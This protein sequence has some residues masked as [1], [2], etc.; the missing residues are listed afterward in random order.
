MAYLLGALQ[1]RFANL[2]VETRL[3]IMTEMLAFARRPWETLLRCSQG[4]R[5][6]VN[7]VPGKGVLW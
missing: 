6:F 2:E 4:T 7:V 5:S 1:M 3:Q